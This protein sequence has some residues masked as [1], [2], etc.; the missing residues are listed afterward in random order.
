[1]RRRSTGGVH[2]DT[3]E[4]EENEGSSSECSSDSESED[5][6]GKEAAEEEDK[7]YRRMLEY[8]KRFYRKGQYAP[9]GLGP[10][11]SLF[12]WSQVIKDSKV[13]EGSRLLDPFTHQGQHRNFSR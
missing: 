5:E 10:G 7:D 4:E 11:E 6:G 9:G 1:M 2:Y 12:A 13:V 3:E 8:Y